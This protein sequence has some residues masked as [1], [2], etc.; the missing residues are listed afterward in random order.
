M[1][2]YIA[3]ALIVL[4]ILSVGISNRVSQNNQAAL[5]MQIYAA[6]LQTQAQQLAQR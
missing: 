5:L 3:T 4:S 2:V 6:L 1:K